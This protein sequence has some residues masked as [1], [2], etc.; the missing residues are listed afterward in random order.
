MGWSKIVTIVL[1]SV[2]CLEVRVVLSQD[3]PAVKWWSPS[4]NTF[5]VV[6]GQAWAAE[7]QNFYDRFPER[8]QKTLDPN[9]W[10]I[11]HSSAGLYLKFQSDANEVIVRYV[12]QNK[13]TF[14]MSHMPATGVS[15]IDLYGLDHNGGWQWAPGSFSFGDTIEYR[16]SN[17]EADHNF[18]GRKC[19]YRLYLPLY[20]SVRWMEIGV[21]QDKSF[22]AMPLSLEKP[23]VVYGTSIAQGACATRP[24]LAWTALLN[25][26]LD[27][28][29]IN[30]GFSGSGKLERSVIDLM[31]EVEAKVFVLDCLPNL[32]SGA[33]FSEGAVDKR[34]TDAVRQLQKVKPHIPVL[35]AEHSGGH[36]GSIMDTARLNEYEKVNKVVRRVYKKL[37]AEVGA[38]VYLLSNQEIG[39]DINATV[40]GIHPNDVG[41]IQYAK[42]YEKAIRTI[43]RETVGSY[44][45]T[46]PVLQSRDGYYDWR[47]RHAEILSLNKAAPPRTIILANSIIHYWGGKPTPP[48]MRGENSWNKYLE[49]SGVRNLGFGW[50]KIENVLWRIHHDELDGYAANHV[51]V[52]IGTNN[53]TTCNDQE[54]T[55]GLK[56]LV[57]AVKVRQPQAK[58]LL[59]GIL[60]RRDM[61]QRVVLL[62]KRIAALSEQSKVR[63][64]DPGK[65]LLNSKG[66]IDE[67]L[68]GDGLHPNEA[69]YEKLGAQLQ[70]YLSK[71]NE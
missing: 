53:L 50:D 61:E 5:P 1:I 37:K 6:E 69:G 68:F 59:S 49:P 56:V 31:T 24:G 42:A 30:L 8:A 17:L 66:R 27:R 39:F 57:E 47:S 55:E 52:M 60:P 32:T 40:D 12:V 19:E 64:I 14:A 43:T 71:T 65:V 22:I 9:V 28:P 3:N 20:N 13:G 44:S 70:I 63:Y 11:S 45:T 7:V 41:M 51:V 2:V 34:I 33:G 38:N 16:F 46:I 29:V 23:I 25:R 67:S 26:S 15:G 36:K 21:A 18:P 48:L 35:L 58:I 62:N 10:N 54:I 4:R